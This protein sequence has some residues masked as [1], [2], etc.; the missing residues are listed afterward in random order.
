IELYS[1]DASIEG[2]NA[3]ITGGTKNLGGETAEELAKYGSNLFLHYHSDEE[4]VSAEEFVES[5]QEFH[6]VKAAVFKGPLDEAKDVTRL[7][8]EA[9]QFFGNGID[10]AINNVGMVLKKPLTEIQPE[11]W[12]KMDTVN[13]KIAF[14]FIQ[15]AAKRINRGGKIVSIVTSLLA[16]YCP[17]YAAY[18]GTMAPVEYYSKTASK[19]LTLKEVS[20][21]CV[22]PGPM[23]TPFFYPQEGEQDVEFYKTMSIKHRLTETTDIVP[24][25]RFLVT[26]GYWITGQTIFCSGGFT[27]R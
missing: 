13:N 15:E 27:A 26:E 7:F 18:Q 3:L 19:E 5:L 10:I 12:E 11:E 21:N 17:G 20:V 14:F 24:I 23:D 1:K 16:A 4:T 9:E 8:T 6:G 25:I 2:K 22:A